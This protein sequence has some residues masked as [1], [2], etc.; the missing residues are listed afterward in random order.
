MACDV[1]MEGVAIGLSTYNPGILKTQST[2]P[3]EQIQDFPCINQ[4]YQSSFRAL[5]TLLKSSH[6][7]TPRLSRFVSHVLSFLMT[8]LM[9]KSIQAATFVHGSPEVV[10]FLALP[11]DMNSS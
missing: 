1:T 10:A 4:R 8:S 6:L 3:N 9:S 2:K 11:Q 7:K 5:Y